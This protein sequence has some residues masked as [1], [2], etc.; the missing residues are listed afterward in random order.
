MPNEAA[1][2]SLSL[3]AFKALPCL[4]RSNHT[5]VTMIVRAMASTHQK[6]ALSRPDRLEDIDLTTL[7]G[8]LVPEPPPILLIC[9]AVNRKTSAMTHVPIAK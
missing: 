1:A 5:V 6:I 8:K 9:A 3:I 2:S 7:T 4:E